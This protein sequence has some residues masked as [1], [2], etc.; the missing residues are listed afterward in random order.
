MSSRAIRNENLTLRL[1]RDAMR[2]LQAAATASHR[3]VNEFILQSALDRADEAL[4]NRRTFGL[5]T[6]QWK[7]FLAALDAPPRP[8]PHLKDLLKKPGFFDTEC[9]L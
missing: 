2:T 3:T 8:L 6:T 4:A 7:A 9:S 5:N 1:T